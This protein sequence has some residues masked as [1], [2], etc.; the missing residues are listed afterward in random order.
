MA[1]ICGGAPGNVFPQMNTRRPCLTGDTVLVYLASRLVIAPMAR[2]RNGGAHINL[3]SSYRVASRYRTTL[4]DRH[5]GLPVFW[6]NSFVGLHA[7]SCTPN[8]KR[9]MSL[10]TAMTTLVGSEIPDVRVAKSRTGVPTLAVSTG[11]LDLSREW[12][13]MDQP[14]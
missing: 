2:H 3:D 10:C 4:S 5:R 14:R 11:R 7:W 6:C 8:G 13:I 12:K 1:I 9:D